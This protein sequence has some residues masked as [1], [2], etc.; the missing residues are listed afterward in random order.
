M[1]FLHER[2]DFMP[3]QPEKKVPVDTVFAVLQFAVIDRLDDLLLSQSEFFS[4]GLVA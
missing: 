4:S 3:Q 1:L 2:F